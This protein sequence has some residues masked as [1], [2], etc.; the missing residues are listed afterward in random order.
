MLNWY[1]KLKRILLID[2]TLSVRFFF[3]MCSFGYGVDIWY[4]HAKD[5]SYHLLYSLAPHWTTPESFWGTLFVFYSIMLLKGIT[6]QYGYWHLIFEAILGWSI[7]TVMAI[8]NVTI[9]GYPEASIGGAIVATWLLV[10]YPTHWKQP[11]D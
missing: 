3:A 7:W 4:D 2:D 1:V 11:H 10:R 8:V 5:Q 6:G 9:T